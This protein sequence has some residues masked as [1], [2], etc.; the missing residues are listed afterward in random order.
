MQTII[1]SQG[2]LSGL[3]HLLKD[4]V[5]SFENQCS[6]KVAFINDWCLYRHICEHSVPSRPGNRK[7]YTTIGA[8]LDIL[9]PY[10]PIRATD[11]NLDLFIEAVFL[12]QDLAAQFSHKAKMDFVATLRAIKHPSQWEQ[13]FT[14]CETIRA[15]KEELLY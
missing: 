11:E 1:L 14:V 5:I 12:P 15:I 4:A 6:A 10:I 8:L 7:K 3:M 9:E 2:Q 13:A